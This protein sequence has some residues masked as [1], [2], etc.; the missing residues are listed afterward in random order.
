MQ[1]KPC[2]LYI[3]FEFSDGLYRHIEILDAGSFNQF[4]VM[5]DLSIQLGHAF[6]VVYAVDDYDSFNAAIDMCTH[7]YQIKGK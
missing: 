1:T 7:I 5:R 2:F 6:A 3:T 4:P